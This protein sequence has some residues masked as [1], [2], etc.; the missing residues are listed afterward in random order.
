MV[1]S[2]VQALLRESEYGLGLE[3]EDLAAP[4]VRGT[5]LGSAVD[6]SPPVIVTVR[7][8]SSDFEYQ[9]PASPRFFV[10]RRAN[11]EDLHRI[12]A[13]GKGTFVL[14]AQSGW[15]KSSLALKLQSMVEDEGGCAVVIDSRT[16]SRPSFVTEALRFAAQRAE[17][18]GLLSTPIDSSWA[19]LPSA[20]ATIE[21]STWHTRKPMVVFFDQFES[22]FLDESTTR[23]FRDL[24]L[25]VNDLS[26]K[27]LI[28]FAWKTDLVGWTESHPYRL[29]DEIR[30]ASVQLIIPQMGARDIEALLRR[31]DK[32][33]GQS[34]ARDLR[35][36]LREYSQGLP[37]LFKKLS[38]PA[39]L[40]SK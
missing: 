30:S 2:P 14:N 29:R 13:V 31:L 20:V 23:P 34:L 11:V 25:L 33:L 28:G 5:S 6:T 9:F 27:L 36:R 1:P 19:S 17:S 26:C 37:W 4:T 32:R 18:V 24:T 22:V 12:V 40:Q 3:I 21:R 8:S 39:Q 16:A 7:G 15:G 10:G 38:E 35:Q